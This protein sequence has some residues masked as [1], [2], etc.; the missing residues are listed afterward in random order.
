MP[1]AVAQN[2]KEHGGGVIINT[3]SLLMIISFLIG[4]EV[5]V[6]L[7]R[8]DVDPEK[9]ALMVDIFQSRDEI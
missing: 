3:D 9:K 8:Q 5:Q 7:I 6:L 1:Q 4:Y 2:T